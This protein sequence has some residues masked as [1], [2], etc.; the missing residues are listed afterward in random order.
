MLIIKGE[1]LYDFPIHLP[2]MAQ[3]AQSPVV[4]RCRRNDSVHSRHWP[5]RLHSLAAPFM[6]QDLVRAEK[7]NAPVPKGKFLL[8]AVLGIAAAT[9]WV[10]ILLR[11]L[12]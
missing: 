9:L 10:Y 3:A 2:N 7:E 11:F 12:L 8:Y 4:R 5:W 1:R 6:V